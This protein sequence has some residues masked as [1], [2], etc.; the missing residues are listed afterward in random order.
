MPGV[1][2]SKGGNVSLAKVDPTIE[3]AIIRLGWAA[4][5]TDGAPFDLDA[6]VFLVTT[7]GKVRN[8]KDFIFYNNPEGDGVRHSGD[9]K[10]G[11][12]EEVAIH[13]RRVPADI[14]RVVAV[15]TI[16]EAEQRRQAFGQVS[17]AYAGIINAETGQEIARYDL[18]E[19]AST[20]TAM[21]FAELYRKNGGWSFRAVGQG[22][23]GGL[24]ALATSFGVD[25]A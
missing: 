22:Y 3:K 6:S 18:Q 16:H 17:D 14:D 10:I 21:I 8:D 25:V 20:E 24:A 19:D 5:A 13:L 2:L 9:N 1:S 15:V 7:A 12:G 11:G 23:A 4:R